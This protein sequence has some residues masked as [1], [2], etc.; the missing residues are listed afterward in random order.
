MCS[1]LSLS[2][3]NMLNF[4]ISA[5][6][7]VGILEDGDIRSHFYIFCGAL[8]I[9][10]FS[11]TGVVSHVRQVVLKLRNLFSEKNIGLTA[12]RQQ[13]FYLC[14]ENSSYPISS[15]TLQQEIYLSNNI[16]IF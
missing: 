3:M 13:H 8:V 10:R 2:V 16:V 4:S 12:T 6:D 9:T 11:E 14:I 15:Y 7:L 1:L 5:I